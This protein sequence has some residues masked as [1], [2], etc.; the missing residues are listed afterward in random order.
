MQLEDLMKSCEIC[1]YFRFPMCCRRVA[2]TR[3]DDYCGDW[4]L[5]AIDESKEEEE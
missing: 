3:H 1:R 2:Y 4:E 5:K